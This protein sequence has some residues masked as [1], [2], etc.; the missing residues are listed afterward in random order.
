MISFRYRSLI[1]NNVVK[2]SRNYS[3]DLMKSSI[4]LRALHDIVYGRPFVSKLWH[5]IRAVFSHVYLQSFL[6]HNI[7]GFHV[8]SS[9]PCWWAVDKRSLSSSFCLST[10]ICSFHHCCLCLPRLHE[11]H[12]YVRFFV[13]YTCVL[14]RSIWPFCHKPTYTC[15]QKIPYIC[16][17]NKHVVYGV[18]ESRRIRGTELYRQ[19]RTPSCTMELKSNVSLNQA[20]PLWPR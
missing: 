16:V 12:L 19:Q 15:A 10:S 3:Q 17:T 11:N 13:T 8:T 20:W 7:G 9:P 5:D 1:Q 18:T 4:V 6:L 2:C 14:F